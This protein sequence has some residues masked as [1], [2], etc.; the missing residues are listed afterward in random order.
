MT[1]RSIT[2]LKCTLMWQVNFIKVGVSRTTCSFGVAF[3]T[4]GA[5]L[6]ATFASRSWRF[7]VRW[8]LSVLLYGGRQRLLQFVRVFRAGDVFSGTVLVL[9]HPRPELSF[10]DFS[11]F[12]IHNI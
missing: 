4:L 1:Y 11:V 3:C 2:V 6:A 7:A 8:M 5:T 10:V 12:P 9:A